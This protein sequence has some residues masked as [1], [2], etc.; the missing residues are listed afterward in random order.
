MAQNRKAPVSPAGVYEF[1]PQNSFKDGREK[2][3]PQNL[4]GTSHN[5]M[6]FAD[7]IGITFIIL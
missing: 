1:D 2:L 6:D 7:K 4:T 5:Y 3:I